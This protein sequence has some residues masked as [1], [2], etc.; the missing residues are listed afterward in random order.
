MGFITAEATA[1]STG[2]HAYAAGDFG[3]EAEGTAFV[4]DN[5][6][7]PSGGAPGSPG[8]LDMTFY[9]HGVTPSS[10]AV[11]HVKVTAYNSAVSGPGPVVDQDIDGIDTVATTGSLGLA[12]EL[13]IPNNISE[14]LDLYSTQG[15]IDFSDTVELVGIAVLDSHGKPVSGDVTG[16]GGLDY[17]KL[18]VSNAAA[19]GLNVGGVPEAS[20]G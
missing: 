9:V 17:T 4:S 3:Y 18:A 13:G 5:Y 7:L 1:D 19:L 15:I 16:D 14:R 2:L 11:G 8:T 20:A 6:F 10:N 12:V